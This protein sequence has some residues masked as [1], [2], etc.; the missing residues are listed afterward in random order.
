MTADQAI[1]NLID[2]VNKINA[3]LLLL[4]RAHLQRTLLRILCPSTLVM[5]N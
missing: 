1:I 2:Q 3:E 5:A 4:M